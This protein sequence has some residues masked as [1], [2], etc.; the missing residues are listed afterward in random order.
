[1]ANSEYPSV[2]N[3]IP[4]HVSLFKRLINVVRGIMEGKTN[5]T[6][7]VTLTASSATTTITLPVGD[8]GPNTTILFMPLSANAAT[9]F[10]AGT[11]YVSSINALTGVFV[12]T[13]VNNAQTDRTFNY[14]L[15]G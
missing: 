9:E 13:H 8:L 10:G 4:D 1:M 5:N 15:I 6:N 14:A 3:Y 11:I 12:I 2:N 7:V